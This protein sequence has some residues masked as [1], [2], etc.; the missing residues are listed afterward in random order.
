VNNQCI[1]LDNMNASVS[2][3]INIPFGK[4]DYNKKVAA[5]E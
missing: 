4:K 2:F 5:V 1:P 3:G